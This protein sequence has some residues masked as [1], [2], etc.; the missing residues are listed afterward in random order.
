M[1]VGRVIVENGMDDLACR[2]GFFDRIEKADEFLMAMAG[3]ASP[4]HGSI[5]DIEGGEQGGGT[6]ALVIVGHGG[7][8]SGFER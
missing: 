3:H 5:E 6:I 4:Q 8:F 2:H 1:L 7:A